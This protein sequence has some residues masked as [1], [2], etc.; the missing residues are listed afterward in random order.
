MEIISTSD[1]GRMSHDIMQHN[2]LAFF[3]KLFDS[4]QIVNSHSP[5]PNK[6][7]L[8]RT[9]RRHYLKH[10]LEIVANYMISFLVTYT[11]L[12]F[13][14]SSLAGVLALGFPSFALLA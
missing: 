2:A 5:G 4:L 9:V 10:N 11:L 1:Q 6:K 12:Y 3:P 8:S 7:G 14:G 13:G